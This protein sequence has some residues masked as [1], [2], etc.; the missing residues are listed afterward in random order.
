MSP[1]EYAQL[2][3]SSVASGC[4]RDEVAIIVIAINDN[5]DACI[6]TNLRDRGDIAKVLVSALEADAN[7]DWSGDRNPPAKA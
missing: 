3:L 1:G 6:V 2:A 5:G 7:P 4:V